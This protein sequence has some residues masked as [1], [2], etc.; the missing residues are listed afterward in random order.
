MASGK[1][2]VEEADSNQIWKAFRL[3][4]KIINLKE[5]KTITYH[6]TFLKEC[7]IMYILCYKSLCLMR[8]L[9][10]FLFS[11]GDYWTGALYKTM[12]KSP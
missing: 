6:S 10:R 8:M 4:V 12:Y 1:Y 2:K 3:V 9:F 7:N 5:E 11:K